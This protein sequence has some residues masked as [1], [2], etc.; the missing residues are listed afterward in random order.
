MDAIEPAIGHHDNEI[1]VTR[2]RDDGRYDLTDRRNVAGV[3][4]RVPKTPNDLV[5]GESLVIRKRR[6]KDRSENHLVRLG[7]LKRPKEVVLKNSTARRGRSRFEDRPHA[8]IGVRPSHGPERFL[9]RGGMMREIV[10][11]RHATNGAAQFEPPADA[12]KLCE[13]PNH[14]LD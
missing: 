8:A 3:A 7:L 12:T 13:R 2:F 6:T 10:E 1:P 11:H 5:H 4:I 14:V 9:D